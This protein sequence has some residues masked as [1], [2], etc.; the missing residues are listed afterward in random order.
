MSQTLLCFGDS[1]THGTPPITTPGTYARYDMS[2]RWPQLTSAALGE[3]W[4]LVEEGLPGRTAQFEDPIMGAFM[5]GRPGLRIALQ[6][7]GPIDVMTLMLGTNDVKTRFGATAEKVTAGIAGLLDIALGDDMQ[8]RH[9]GFKVLLICPP[10]VQES[11]PFAGEFY[12]GEAVSG[13][14][15]PLY[16]NLAR[17][18]GIGFL[19]AGRVL[20]VSPV[21]GVHYAP[22]GHVLLGRAV[23]NAVRAF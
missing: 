23:A 5:D 7:H 4:N 12:G 1:N 20:E 9:N 13:A 16:E 19:D 18:R 22:D 15:P 6:S 2:I 8:T 21:D 11:G 14:L 17:A 10:P 3:D